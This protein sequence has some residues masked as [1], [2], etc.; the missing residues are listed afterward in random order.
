METGIDAAAMISDILTDDDIK[1]KVER[2]VAII[3]GTS[4]NA[5]FPR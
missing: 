4:K 3:E 5:L 1:G 2:L